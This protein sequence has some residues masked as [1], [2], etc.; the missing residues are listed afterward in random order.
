MYTLGEE[1]SKAYSKG[2]EVLKIYSQGELVYE[3][4]A[5][6]PY[7]PYRYVICNI[8]HGYQRYDFDSK[9]AFETFLNDQKNNFEGKMKC[10]YNVRGEAEFT[11]MASTFRDCIKVTEIDI[12]DMDIPELT[13]FVV[14]FGG[15]DELTKIVFPNS[16]LANLTN[17]NFAFLDCRALRTLD[18]TRFNFNNLTITAYMFHK[19][20]NF[21]SL[22]LN[23]SA[24]QKYPKDCKLDKC[25]NVTIYVND[26]LV[27][28]YKK[29]VG[30]IIIKNK[31]KPYS[32]YVPE[33]EVTL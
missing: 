33:E 21:T 14:T 7:S 32:E 12:S 13:S 5:P 8:G 16:S 20:N 26:R 25:P 3:K 1:V 18:L 11:V 23:Q 22:I 27:E 24:L 10:G 28:E 30:W 19:M 9:A 6:P 17:M 2:A 4:S 29:A 31:I 15:C